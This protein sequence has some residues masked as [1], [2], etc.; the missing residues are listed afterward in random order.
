MRWDRS[1]FNG[2]YG[3]WDLPWCFFGATRFFFPGKWRKKGWGD[4][5]R[6]KVAMSRRSRTSQWG[7]KRYCRQV[8]LSENSVPQN[9]MVLLIIIPIKWLF[10]WEYTLFS[11]KPKWSLHIFFS[12]KLPGTQVTSQKTHSLRG[13]LK[14]GRIHFGPGDAEISVGVGP[15]CQRSVWNSWKNCR[16]DMLGW[17]S[18]DINGYFHGYFTNI[19]GVVYV[20]D[21]SPIFHGYS[22]IAMDMNGS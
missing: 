2:S 21:I 14:S 18:W 5:W 11:D 19:S 10:H 9:P 12:M 6:D 8:G 16:W 20:T 7:P 13:L 4:S 1:I 3:H 15:R 17:Y 22:V